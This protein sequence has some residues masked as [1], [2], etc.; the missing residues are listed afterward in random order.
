MHQKIA[1]KVRKIIES[2]LGVRPT[3]QRYRI[4]VRSQPRTHRK[5]KYIQEKKLAK[6]HFVKRLTEISTTYNIS[7]NMMRISSAKTRWGSCSRKR[8][9]NLNWRLIFAPPEVLDY[10]ITHELSHLTHMNHSKAFWAHVERMMP[11]YK[12]H[13]TWLKKNGRVLSRATNVVPKDIQMLSIH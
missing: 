7:Y 13:R 8:N 5:I 11:D 2:W 3:G 6:L 10:V 12:T 9:I 4:I 1:K